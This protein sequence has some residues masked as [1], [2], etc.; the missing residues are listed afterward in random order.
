MKAHDDIINSN[1]GDDEDADI[2]DLVTATQQMSLDQ[3]GGHEQGHEQGR[4]QVKGGG[5]SLTAPI[6]YPGDTER[7]TRINVTVLLVS[8]RMGSVGLNLTDAQSVV[9]YEPC[10]N[11][12]VEKQAQDRVHRIGQRHPVTVH[13]LITSRTV[14]ERVRAV[15][16]SKIGVA[17]HILGSGETTTKA[18]KK[19]EGK[20]PSIKD[21]HSILY[22][23]GQ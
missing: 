23:K 21:L 8:M 17:R 18:K 22:F 1:I 13:R 10:W 20:G 15:Q 7:K 12:Q 4:E 19:V 11:P 9:L 5:T 3:R 6:K 14:E 2:N 16:Q